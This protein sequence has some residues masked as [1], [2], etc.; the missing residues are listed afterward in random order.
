[1]PL[2]LLSVLEFLVSSFELAPPHLGP[3]VIEDERKHLENAHSSGAFQ[4]S[5]RWLWEPT[6][7]I[8]AFGTRNNDDGYRG[9]AYPTARAPGTLRIATI[10]D[11]STFGF[12]VLE[13]QCWSRALERVLREN[14]VA[15]E[16]LNFGCVGHTIRQGIALLHGRIAD[17]RPDVVVAAF[18]AV[19]EQ[20]TP[21]S[22]LTDRQKLLLLSGSAYRARLFL[23]RYGLF[24]FLEARFADD[25]QQ[26]VLRGTTP[27]RH[28][29]PPDEFSSDLAE[30]KGEADAIGARLLLVSPP[31]RRDAEKTHAIA[32]L[33][34]KILYDR[35]PQLGVALVP[36]RETIRG[37][38]ERLD[39]PITDA[40][41]PKSPFFLDPYHPSPRGHELY[42]RLVAGA[43]AT[44]GIVTVS[45]PADVA[46]P[47]GPGGSRGS[48]AG[49]ASGDGPP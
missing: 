37:A 19:N 34:T 12:D 29:V 30:L 14:G 20:F 1:M 41:G 31:R 48:D 47:R 36:V 7:G 27:E 32:T 21:L 38:E 26:V 44:A 46:A 45:P 24:R 11:S 10:G 13:E 35:A 43:L 39:P 40:D 23:R 5:P 42:A 8:V 3:L 33:Y 17:Y 6:P 15:V 16:V 28:R 18:G 25:D 2:L 49:G 22:G 9:P 4:F